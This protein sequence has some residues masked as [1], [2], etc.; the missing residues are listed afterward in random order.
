MVGKKEEKPALKGSLTL[1]HE[2]EEH[3]QERALSGGVDVEA[4]EHD[5]F[6]QSPPSPPAGKGSSSS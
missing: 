1:L 3:E 5:L 2:E 6:S 4:D